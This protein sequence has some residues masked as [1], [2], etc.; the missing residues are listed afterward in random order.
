MNPYKRIRRCLAVLLSMAVVLVLGLLPTTETA[1]A[2]TTT[3]KVTQIAAAQDNSI[4]LKSDGTVIAWGD[5]VTTWAKPPEGLTDV[6]EIYAKSQLFLAR[7][8]NGTVVAW[9][10]NYVGERDIPSGLT[11]VISMASGGMN[12]L[13]VVEDPSVAGTGGV[14]AWGN[15]GDG[16]SVPPD[17]AKS[18]VTKVAAGNYYSM[19]L[20]FNGTVVEWGSNGPGA[21]LMPAG[22]SNVKEIE[23]GYLFALALKS[24]GTIAAWGKEYNGNGILN[25][26]SELQGQTIAISAQNNHALALKRDGKV[27]GWGT[28]SRGKATPPEGLTDVVAISAGI[29]HSLALKRDGTV[30]SWGSQTSV[31]G[32]NELSS[33]TVTEG[34]PSPAFSPSGTSYQYDIAPG[35]TSVHI[36]AV[37]NDSAYSALYINDQ[38]QTSGSTVVVSVPTTGA[39]I[40]VR[41]EPYMKA[42][43]TYTLTIS[44]DRDPP[45]IAL[46][47]NGSAV[48]LRGISTIVQVADATSGVNASTLEYAWTQ[49]VSAPAAGWT[50]FYFIPYTSISQFVHS[51]ADGNWY[52][53]IRAKDYAGNLANVTSAPFL[54]D[55]TPPVVSMTVKTEDG[56]AYPNNDWTSQDVVVTAEATDAQSNIVLFRYSLDS[57]STWTVYSGPVTFTESGVYNIIFQAQD[58]I[59]NVTSVGR[60]VK[61]SHG[62]LKLTPTMTR[63]ADGGVY[64]S[65]EWTNSSVRIS[66]TTQTG[67]HPIVSTTMSLNGGEAWTYTPG[68]TTTLLQEGTYS[69]LFKVTDAIGNSLSVPLAINMDKSKPTVSFSPN[70]NES[71]ARDASVTATVA[72]SGGSGMAESTLEYVWTQ[73]NTTKPTAGWQRLN[74]GSTLTKEGLDGDWYLHIQGKDTAGNEGYAVSGRFILNH[75]PLN[76]TL[77]PNTGSFDKKMSAQADVETTLELNGNMLD[78][79]S[80]GAGELVSG[81]DYVIAGNTVIFRKSYLSTQP[82]GTTS[83][84]FT[85]SGGADQTL[86]ITVSDTTPL[87]STISPDTGSFDKK[88]SAQADVVTTMMLHGNTLARISN[89]ATA[90]V[91]GTE[92]NVAGNTVTILKNYLAAQPLGVT[93]LTFTFSAGVNQTLILSISDTT[94]SNSIITPNTGNFDKKLSAQAD[95][96]TTLALNGNTLASIYNGVETLVSGTDYTVS[97]DTVTIL[98]SYLAGQSLGTTS[99]TFTFSAGMDQTLAILV[100]DTTVPNST[101][102]PITGSFD[103]KTAAQ[104]DV[105]ATMTLNGNILAG[106]SNGAA[107]LAAGMDYIVAGST[108]T[109]LKSYLATQSVG[110]T[111][112]TF[113]FSAGTDRT[114]TITV[115][116]TTPLNSTISPNMGSFDKK[117]AAQAD[118][119]ATMTLNGNTLVAIRNGAAALLSGT[120][121][122][123]A[124]STVTILKSYLAARPVG[125]TS[126]TFTFSAGT[127]QTLNIS[128]S[129]STPPNSTI[130][131]NTGSFDKKT[132]AQADVV[133]TMTLNGN[134]LAGIRNG[135]AA[136]LS[137]TDYTVAGSTVT[138]L[139]S[140]LAAQPIG[141]TSLTFSF[142]AGVNQALTITVSDT[143]VPNSMISPNTGS[144]DKKTAAQADI[145][146]TMTLNGHTLAGI[147]NGATVLVSGTEYT[148]AGSTVTI[149]K[150]YLAAQS[151]GTA[152][153]TFT[154]SG[155]ADQTLTITVSDTTVPGYTVT[156][157]GNGSTEG[158]TPL[159][160]GSYA[161]GV[162]VSVY[163][164]SGNLSKTGYT[165]TGWNTQADGNG[166]NYAAEAIFTMGTANVTL[167]AKWKSNNAEL[168]GLT[169]PGSTLNPIFAAT[170]TS[171]TVNVT[172][173]VS[174]ITVTATVRDA[175][176]ATVT[177]RVYNN[178]GTITSGPIPLTSG[179]VSPSL[180]LNVGINL[181]NLVV[182]AEDGTTKTYVVTVNRASNDGGEDGSE[183]SNGGS[184]EPP[185]VPSGDHPPDVST[186]ESS[187][188]QPSTEV[189]PTDTNPIITFLDIVG[190]WAEAYIKQT[191]RM[192]IVAGYPDGTF[193][194]NRTVT[195]AEFTVML[196]NTLKLPGE[197]AALTFTDTAKI[198]SWAQKAVAQAVQAGIISGYEDGSFHPD[199]EI[200]RA[201]MAMMLASASRLSLEANTATGFADDR[202]IPA[203]AKDAVSAIKK[204][205]LIQGKGSNEF[206]P[207]AGTTRAEAVTVLMR[208][209]AQKS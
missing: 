65:G 83:L 80:D 49:T 25:V 124:G 91:S 37:L 55:N 168:S 62:D 5:N 59:G 95:V 92:Y 100:S 114:L 24:D 72:D 149:T 51:G 44:R 38:L 132:A 30:V 7:K 32:D 174:S 154:F 4:A 35:A 67:V 126:L 77:S 138:I 207:N 179:A 2:E 143:T 152:S 108:V 29:S 36:K 21:T 188:V 172:K 137:G 104:A 47:P 78:S 84:T 130:S 133:A 191:A 50:R 40:K 180:P 86:K 175:V 148:V 97:G 117:T 107:A 79:I 181:I 98:Q 205:G 195:R 93:S 194:P 123:V 89:G 173:S 196:M 208:M 136:L 141:T 125:T 41:V 150:S 142:S 76:S 202:D 75:S 85:F 121:Y 71:S 203:W 23:A 182:T 162:A 63:T 116:D 167:Y 70:G 161:Q 144:F 96:E 131:P 155:G 199:E 20:K 22:L 157:S 189:P 15:N 184:T 88:I 139:K 66:A 68:V 28:N 102:S 193:K 87:N 48:P 151:V 82:V 31:P 90:L 170:T 158:S 192:G 145:V 140:Y 185:T 113:T 183:G 178:V 46:S 153:L 1:N 103:K 11:K 39:V 61:I 19:A 106:I 112:L 204:L 60:T 42:A 64:T 177:A 176:Y 187:T 27:V 94:T 58:T 146:A 12:T 18:L 14:V 201:E 9:G 10:A 45:T 209:L 156:Y 73:N 198:G 120:D 81:T 3:V 160:G 57:G 147:T 43:K 186:E 110:T 17:T 13:L 169:L 206:D 109:I 119:L 105:V 56:N 122:T 53:H 101:I 165:F 118:V 99:L 197:G 200:T 16:Q 129:D 135:A 159:D 33:L 134:T 128:V 74:N 6:V 115:S 8:S 163:G 111:S 54:I 69:I 26:P 34:S 164:N 171:Y 52:L 127:D 166:T 190:H